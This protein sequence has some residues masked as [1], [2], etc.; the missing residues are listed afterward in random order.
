MKVAACLEEIITIKS[1]EDLVQYEPHSVDIRHGENLQE[2]FKAIFP[3]GKIPAMV[4]PHGPN[5]T[6]IRVFESGSIL[7][8]LAEKYDVLLPADRIL[9]VEA[10]KWLFF[11][12]STISVQF[13]MF[14]FYYKYC[15]GGMTYSLNRYA[16]E[17]NRLLLVL[18]NQLLSHGKHWIV[19]G[20]Q[21]L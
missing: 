9:R 16:A 11:G 2:D 15:P 4:D 10:I 8:Y 14:G 6:Q 20:T 13:K 12:C 5:E 18:D 19:G 17:C 7:L 3:N 21:S 1:V